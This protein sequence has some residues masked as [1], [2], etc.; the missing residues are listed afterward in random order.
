LAG[1]A[2]CRGIDQRHKGCRVRHQDGVEQD[3]VAGLQ[4]SEKE[5]FLQVVVEPGELSMDARDLDFE[6]IG[7]R[8]QQPFD[9]QHAAIR[10]G[11]SA[12]SVEVGVVKEVGACRCRMAGLGHDCQ[13]SR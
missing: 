2:D 7:N 5:V 1:L 6:S 3:L 4:V 10:E 9:A 13:L 12:A 8:R 11:E